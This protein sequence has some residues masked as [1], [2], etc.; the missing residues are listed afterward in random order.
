MNV[1]MFFQ[2]DFSEQLDH[3]DPKKRNTLRYSHCLINAQNT[4]LFT[5]SI[6]FSCSNL[7]ITVPNNTKRTI[8]TPGKG[9]KIRIHVFS[10]HTISK[11]RYSKYL[12]IRV[13]M[14]EGVII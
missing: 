9:V 8:L 12:M 1:K 6:R 3:L 10:R 11:I 5:L 13:V 7:R 14:L 2:G 4:M